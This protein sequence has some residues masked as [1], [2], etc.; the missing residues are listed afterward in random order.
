MLHRCKGS[1]INASHRFFPLAF[2]SISLV[3]LSTEGQA[4]DIVISTPVTSNQILGSDGD[5][6]TITDTGSLSITNFIAGIVSTGANA[7]ITNNGTIS[8]NSTN[9][10]GIA[11]TGFDTQ[12]TNSGTISTEGMLAS[13]ILSTFNTQITN[14]G[15]IDVIG[16]DSA[17][18]SLLGP[19]GVI[20]SLTNSGTLSAT[21]AATQAIV[22][23]DADTT[24]T[25]LPGSNIIG[26]IDLGGG[27]DTLNIEGAM[28][29]DSAISNVDVLNKNNAGTAILVGTNTYSGITMINGGALAVNGSISNSSTT[30]N[31]AGTLSGTGT[32][33]SV[34][35]NG[36]T[37]APG[38]SIGSLSLTG[39]ITFS[40]GGVYQVE[41]DADGNSDLITTTGAAILTGGAVQVQPEAGS[42]AE[43]TG[44]TI[45]TAAGGLGDT[46]FE[47]VSSTLAFLTPTLGYDANNVYLNLSRNDVSF[48]SVTNTANQFSVSRAL[49]SLFNTNQTSTADILD[50]VFI[51]T[52]TGAQQAFESLSGVQ[53]THSQLATHQSTQR[54][55]QVLSNRNQ[56]SFGTLAYGAMPFNANADL[57][58]AFNGDL[59]LLGASSA[60]A[61]G[62]SMTNTTSKRGW[63]IQGFGGTGEINDTANASGADLDSAGLAIG[64]DTEWAE[65]V[66]GLAGSY[67]NTEVD[68]VSSDLDI[69]SYQLA[70]Y[71]LWERNA[72]YLSTLLNLGQHSTDAS[73]NISVGTLF[74]AANADYDSESLDVSIELGNTYGEATGTTTTPYVRLAYQSLQQ[75][76]F[77][78]TGAG[79]M[80]LSVGS[81]ET[82]GV[83]ATFGIRFQDNLTT[84]NG[85]RLTPFVDVAYVRDDSNLFQLDADFAVAPNNT[86]RVEGTELDKSRF[87]L[88]FG[89]IGNV[90]ERITLNLGYQGE[91][92]GSDKQHNVSAAL[93]F[94]W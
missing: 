94:I 34:T 18:V 62:Q 26:S 80:N 44:Y 17:A 64:I 60:N 9:A 15:T 30:V 51:L 52:D 84:R 33:G 1:L 43:T 39:D 29:L 36:G 66:I 67:T 2:L 81:E 24:V 19:G 28:I 23:G 27:T 20:N 49:S 41:V 4:V 92:A 50:A 68:A 8:T 16:I 31:S 6:L 71:G 48:D 12:I 87:Q 75:D 78:E 61:V 53:H 89:V 45:L 70:V 35:L 55:Q 47:S 22:S 79:S 38:N 82:D 65:G 77:V 14:S 40:S 25:L 32:V 73:R 57:L 69:N 46:S 7:Q 59:S 54:F 21:G 76:R 42:Y 63:W 11:S 85:K 74:N 10:G 86:F 3:G 90:S 83:R 88:G 72:M 5:T 58:L 56:R 37:I 93:R 91:F 13:G